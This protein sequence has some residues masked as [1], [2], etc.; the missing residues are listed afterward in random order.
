MR[1][2]LRERR[3][4]RYHGH[5]ARFPLR[6]LLFFQLASSR[7]VLGGKHERRHAIRDELADHASHPGPDR[8]TGRRAGKRRRGGYTVRRNG[9]W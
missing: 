1:Y 3:Y 9:S 6:R 7:K 4:R 8:D 5:S 2:R